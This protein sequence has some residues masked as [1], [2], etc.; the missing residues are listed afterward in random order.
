MHIF[1]DVSWDAY[2]VLTVWG[3]EAR[4]VWAF[5]P[6]E[7]S[8][9]ICPPFQAASSPA[10]IPPKTGIERMKELRK[11]KTLLI[12]DVKAALQPRPLCMGVWLSPY[13]LWVHSTKHSVWMESELKKHIYCLMKSMNDS[14]N[15]FNLAYA[16]LVGVPINYQL[17]VFTFQCLT[18]FC[19]LL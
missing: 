10:P 4:A 6:W 12:T 5:E 16:F 1:I 2:S 14:S 3:T 15:Q 13:Y 11:E 19:W 7:D 17:P 18:I 9:L 8:D